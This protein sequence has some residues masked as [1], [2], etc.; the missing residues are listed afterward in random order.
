M[1]QEDQHKHKMVRADSLE[2]G[3]TGRH[4]C[5]RC[6]DYE[7]ERFRIFL[8]DG[9]DKNDF[10]KKDHKTYDVCLGCIIDPESERYINSNGTMKY[11]ALHKVC[12]KQHWD[13]IKKISIH[14]DP[15]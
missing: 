3:M 6:K 9:G 2:A 12:A 5:E 8:Q 14:S 7:K 15:R 4:R 13:H 10:K 1:S 11:L